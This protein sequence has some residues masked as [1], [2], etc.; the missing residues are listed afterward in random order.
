MECLLSP[1]GQPTGLPL[2]QLLQ[3]LAAQSS[4]NGRPALLP[5]VAATGDSGSSPVAACFSSTMPLPLLPVGL[6]TG[7][8]HRPGSPVGKT[9]TTTG[10]VVPIDQPFMHDDARQQLTWQCL[11][12]TLAGTSSGLWAPGSKGS[13]LQTV[14]PAGHGDS[15]AVGKMG[16]KPTTNTNTNTSNVASVASPTGQSSF[17]S[18]HRTPGLPSAGDLGLLLLPDLSAST[19]FTLAT[20]TTQ[21]VTSPLA[22]SHTTTSTTATTATAAAAA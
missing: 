13:G 22:T 14:S 10:L 20:A 2:F 6:S 21:P 17:H 11:L 15:L 5:L 18:V 4:P 7:A 1:A 8:Q 19:P 9:N 12:H 3:L 16:K